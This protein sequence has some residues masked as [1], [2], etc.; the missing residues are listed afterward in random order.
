MHL[1]HEGD[2]VTALEEKIERFK[3]HL[4]THGLLSQDP[5]GAIRYGFIHGNWALD[6]SD[7]AGR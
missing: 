7:A 3:A 4:V 1:H 2:S 6:N 5:G